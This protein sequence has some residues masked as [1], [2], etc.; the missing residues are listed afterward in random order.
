MIV[1]ARPM[2]DSQTGFT[3]VELIVVLALIG[4]FSAA[5]IV[6][7]P[8]SDGGLRAEQDRLALLIDSVRDNAI[9]QSRP[10]A[11]R[12]ASTQ[13]V[14]ETRTEGNWQPLNEKPFQP[15]QLS[16]GNNVQFS[17][18]D[19]VRIAFDS[20]GLP[21]SS[22]DIKISNGTDSGFIKIDASGRVSV[23]AAEN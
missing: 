5:V 21:V 10:M 4:L 16:A 9:V 17:G 18:K 6:N 3:L 22:A 1:T 2:R 8:K 13:Y 12:I 11:V 19:Y 14:F 23:V 15:H 7:L 20:T